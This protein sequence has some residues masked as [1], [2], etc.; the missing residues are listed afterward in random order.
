MKKERKFRFI[1]DSK[2]Y[3]WN[4]NPINGKIYT[5]DVINLMTGFPVE[6][7]YDM[8]KY[9]CKDNYNLLWREVFED[10][11]ETIESL[12][13]KLKE[14]ANSQGMNCDV[15]IE[16]KKNIEVRFIRISGKYNALRLHFN[17]SKVVDPSVFGDKMAA[18]LQ[19]LLN[20][21]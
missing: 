14:L 19:E 15:V 11:H 2:Y 18:Y 8:L 6:I 9:S 10:E 17:F 4:K 3:T 21:N 5:L 16:E 12:T 1:G 13:A 20:E 7:T